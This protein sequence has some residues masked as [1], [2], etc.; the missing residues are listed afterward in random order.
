MG[1]TTNRRRYIDEL[2][3]QMLTGCDAPSARSKP[4]L[5]KMIGAVFGF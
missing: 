2:K 3:A 4:I 5:I 1:K